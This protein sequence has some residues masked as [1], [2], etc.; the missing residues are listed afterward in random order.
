MSEQ[1][2]E[3]LERLYFASGGNVGELL[4]RLGV[5]RLVS[6]GARVAGPIFGAEPPR[7]E[8]GRFALGAA[9]LR[10]CIVSVCRAGSSWPSEDRRAI[11]RARDAYDDGLAIMCTGREGPFLL[12][13]SIPRK[14]PVAPINYFRAVA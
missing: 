3:E 2:P 13:Y 1:Q 12:L 10:D 9:A 14:A 4:A 8:K 5:G 6:F 7:D 11:Q